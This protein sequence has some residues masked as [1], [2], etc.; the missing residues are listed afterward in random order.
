MMKKKLANKRLAR[1]KGC[2]V[3]G[4]HV[5][6]RVPEVVT[7]RTG[8]LRR[9]EDTGRMEN[10]KHNIIFFAFALGFLSDAIG[11]PPLYGRRQR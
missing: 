6:C 8:G 7:I 3:H 5:R 9:I 11:A 10:I 2:P 4:R 1:L